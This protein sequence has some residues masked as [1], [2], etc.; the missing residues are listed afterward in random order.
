MRLL[1]LAQRI[2]AIA[3]AFEIGS[4]VQFDRENQGVWVFIGEHKYPQ[5][6]R[7]L[8]QGNTITLTVQGG[9]EAIAARIKEIAECEAFQVI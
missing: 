9:G 2:C 8:I 6:V 1:E 7:C 4:Q 5:C 3:N